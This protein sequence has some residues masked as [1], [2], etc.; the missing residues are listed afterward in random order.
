M[1][2]ARSARRPRKNRALV[3]AAAAGALLA[4]GALALPGDPDAPAST[5]T[6][7]GSAQRSLAC[8]DAG[9]T[10]Y[11]FG[12]PT[13]K[14]LATEVRSDW[15]K[16]KVTINYTKSRSAAVSATVSASASAE[17]GVIFA[18]AS[19]EIGVSVG[20]QWTWTDQWSYQATVPTKAGGKKVK[21]ARLVMFHEAKKF[22]VTKKRFAT[23][24]RGGCVTR[25]VWKATATAPVKKNSNTW[26]L[27]YQ[28][29]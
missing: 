3:A 18:K 5:T 16:P 6:L 14:W 9:Q 11:K 28:Y 22:N 19:V 29:K 21:K 12:R 8:P 1:S 24:P 20:S 25:T 10:F 17:A 27:Q 4:G 23:G 2:N 13:T 7:A 26:G 15:A